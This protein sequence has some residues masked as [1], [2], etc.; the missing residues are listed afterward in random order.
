M[1]HPTFRIIVVIYHNQPTPN[2]NPI[3]ASKVGAQLSYEVAN[4]PDRTL[5]IPRAQWF[6]SNAST[7]DFRYN[8]HHGFIVAVVDSEVIALQDRHY[9]ELGVTKAT[10]KVRSV[11]EEN[12]SMIDGG[13]FDLSCV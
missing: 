6:P 13:V 7:V 3:N 11:L 2:G 12:G 1:N 4:A 5:I 10:L 8:D 9:V